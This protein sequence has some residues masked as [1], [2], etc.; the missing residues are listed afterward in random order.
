MNKKNLLFLVIFIMVLAAGVF[1]YF[2][3]QGIAPQPISPALSPSPEKESGLGENLSDYFT[4][5]S[6]KETSKTITSIGLTM[7]NFPLLDGATSTQPV[8]SLIACEALNFECYWYEAEGREM[9]L[10]ADLYKAG[11]I[12][13][14]EQ[15]EIRAKLEKNSKTHDAYLNLINKKNDLILVSTKP[16]DDE[17]RE[18]KKQGVKLELTPVG[19][20]GFVFLVNQ[21][22]PIQNLN[23]KDI[24][25]I[26]S[27]K[28]KSWTEVEGADPSIWDKLTGIFS[29]IA[30]F[31]RPVNSGSQELMEKLVM[32]GVSMDKNL[33]EE[34]VIMAMAPLIEGVEENENSIGYSLYYYKNNMIDKRDRRPNV[35]LISVNGIE[36]NPE[37]IASKKYSYVFDI[38]AVTREDEPKDSLS[39]QIKEWLTSKEGQEII[40]KAGYVSLSN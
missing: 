40:K 13:Y 12:S 10:K 35:K 17:L 28:I 11:V 21:K 36:P 39:Y 18:A 4:I 31:T 27:G 29:S 38:Y 30:A 23:A 6:I 22:N 1:F 8:R 34:R 14:E 3:D 32:K 37:N 9:F 26:Y 15:Q 16:S 5:K 2:I 20:D 24:V 19:L 33:K 7:D 25:D